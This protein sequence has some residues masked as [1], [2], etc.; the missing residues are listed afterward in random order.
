MVLTNEQAVNA[1]KKRI[2]ELKSDY[3]IALKLFIKKK[4]SGVLIDVNDVLCVHIVALKYYNY[5]EDFVGNSGL[6]GAHKN[7]FWITSFAEDCFAVLESLINHYD[8]INSY[9]DLLVN[10]EPSFTSYSNMQRIVVLYIDNKEVLKLMKIFKLKNLPVNGFS[11]EV[12][13]IMNKDTQKTFSFI[14]GVVFLIILLIITVLIPNP[15][16]Y[17]ENIFWVVLALAGGGAVAAFPGFIEVKFGNWLRAGGALAVFA[18]IYLISPASDKNN[19]N[20]TKINTTIETVKG[21]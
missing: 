13:H 2:T 18:V 15:T 5:V 7:D 11:N 6:L 16:K 21:K 17:Q 14:F 12:I 9:N 3:L 4:D 8:F 10:S 1:E 20:Q 19:Q